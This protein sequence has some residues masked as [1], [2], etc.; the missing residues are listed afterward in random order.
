MQTQQVFLDTNKP[1]YFQATPEQA[2]F[3]AQRLGF[4][5]VKHWQEIDS[6]DNTGFL[7]EAKK[8]FAQVNNA[9]LPISVRYQAAKVLMRDKL[10]FIANANDALENDMHVC[11]FQAA[12]FIYGLKD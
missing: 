8:E 6:T 11:K 1:F 10:I 2:V 12:A 7:S 5:V 3:L 4:D 9:E